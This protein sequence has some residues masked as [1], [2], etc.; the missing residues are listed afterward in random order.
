[1]NK[2]KDASQ[3]DSLAKQGISDLAVMESQ[4]KENISN[5]DSAYKKNY[6]QLVAVNNQVLDRTKTVFDSEINSLVKDHVAKK[7]LFETKVQDPFY[8]LSE[9]QYNIKDMIDHYEL[10]IPTP[11]YERD[12]YIVN[13]NDR[14]ISIT[15]SRKFSDRVTE[16]DKTLHKSA[17]SEVVTKELF[18]ADILNPKKMTTGY[19][20]GMLTYLIAKK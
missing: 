15:F 10:T 7:N 3:K 5:R 17:R 12:N 19:K 2:I 16:E 20:D 11:E 8:R 1:V 4:F 9:I 18:T 6:E 14:K 13:G